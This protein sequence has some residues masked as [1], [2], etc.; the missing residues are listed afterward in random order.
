M[1]FIKVVYYYLKNKL[2][3]EIRRVFI[4]KIS[5]I[6]NSKE[7]WDICSKNKFSCKIINLNHFKI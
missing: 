7:L 3:E 6:V 4:V 2:T 5:Y 1:R